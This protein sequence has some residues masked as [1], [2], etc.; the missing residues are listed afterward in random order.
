MD[1]A[2]C[3]LTVSEACRQTV[4]TV[5]RMSTNTRTNRSSRTQPTKASG[6]LSDTRFEELLARVSTF[7]AA[8]EGHSEEERQAVIHEINALMLQYGLTAQ[9]LL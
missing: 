5:V 1:Q 6:F 2:G 9:D 7:F 8:A 4:A 3:F